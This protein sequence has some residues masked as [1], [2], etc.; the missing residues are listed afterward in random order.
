MKQEKTTNVPTPA[1]QCKKCNEDATEPQNDVLDLR[2]DA[3]DRP[4]PPFLIRKEPP[5]HCNTL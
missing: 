3:T 5:Y 1:K 4:Y 2:G